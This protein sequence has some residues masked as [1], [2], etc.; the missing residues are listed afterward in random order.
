MSDTDT[1]RRTDETTKTNTDG[2]GEA[3]DELTA[4]S[5]S[6]QDANRE[7]SHQGRH[8]TGGYVPTT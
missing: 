6:D 1:Y 2:R 4:A 3:A 7:G 5:G 8:D